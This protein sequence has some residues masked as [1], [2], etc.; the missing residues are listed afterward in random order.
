MCVR[1]VR[2]SAAPDRGF[3]SVH[4]IPRKISLFEIQ[5]ENAFSEK[6]HNA[7][8]RATDRIRFR[9]LGDEIGTRTFR[10]VPGKVCIGNGFW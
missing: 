2:F 3:S 6:F 5:S 1:R 10:P 8:L 9:S 7:Y 4:F